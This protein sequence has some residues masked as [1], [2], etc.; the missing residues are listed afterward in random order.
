MRVFNRYRPV[1]IMLELNSLL[2]A[3]YMRDSGWLAGTRLADVDAGKWLTL[4]DPENG[5]GAAPR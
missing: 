5:T 4:P 3:G 1:V 2:D